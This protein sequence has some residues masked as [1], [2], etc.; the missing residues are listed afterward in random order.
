MKSLTDKLDEI[1][2]ERIRLAYTNG[3]IEGIKM[4]AWWKDGTQYVGCGR[5]TLKQAIEDVEKQYI[6]KSKLNIME[7]ILEP[8][9]SDIDSKWKDD[10]KE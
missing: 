8:D 3:M 2:E 10:K 4:Y 9:Y 1:T 6:S 7:M 5:E